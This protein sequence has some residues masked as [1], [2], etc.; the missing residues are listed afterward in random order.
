M[1]NFQLAKVIYE[2]TLGKDFIDIMQGCDAQEGSIIR[3]IMRLEN[4]LKNFKS[5]AKIIGHMPLSHKLDICMEVIK[6]DIVFT[7]SLYYEEDS[8]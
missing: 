3:T 7:Q 1:L 5:A 8:S 2:W 4:L 6:R